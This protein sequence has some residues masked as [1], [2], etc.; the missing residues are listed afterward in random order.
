MKLDQGR[1]RVRQPDAVRVGRA[2]SR[3]CAT[4]IDR[5]R[6]EGVTRAVPAR[7]GDH[8]LRLRGRVLHGR[9]AGHRVRACSRR[10]RRRPRAWSSRSGCPSITR[11]RSTTRPRCSSTAGSSG[12]VA[13][14]FLA[15]D[16][17]H[18][19]PRWFKAWPP[20][21]VDVL[22]R[23]AERRH[24]PPLPDRRPRVRRRRRPHRLRDLRGRVGREPSRHRPRAARRRHHP[25][26]RRA[27]HFAFGKFAVRQR[28]VI[29]G[30]RAFGVA[31]LYAN[32]LG[33]EAGR[34]IY[35]GGALIASGGELLARGRRLVVPRRRAR[36][37]GRS[38]STATAASR[39]AAAATA[40]ATTPRPQVIEHA[41]R[42]ARAQARGAAAAR[43]A[44]GRI[45]ASLKEEE[46]ARAVALGLWDYL[47]KSRAQGYVVSLSGGA[48]SAAC[49]VLVATAVQLAFAELGAG[50]VR[51]RLPWCRRLVEALDR[52]GSPR[53]VVGALLTCAYQPTENSGPV[54]RA[55]GRAGRRRAVGAE[56]HVIDVERPAQGVHRE[57]SSRRSAARSTWDTDD[58]TLQN[59]Q[60]R[61]RAP[62]IWML[63]NLRGALP[64]HDVEPHRG[65]GRLRDD[66]RRHLR[67]GSRRSAASTRRSCAQW[68]RWME[69]RGPVGVEPI[70][71]LAAINAQ[72]PT[73]E[74]RPAELA[75]RPTRPTS[76][77][78]T[79]SRRSRTRRSATSTR[80]S[81]CCRSSRRAIP[82]HAPA[83]LAIWIERFFRLWC[84]NQWKRERLRA[85]LPPRRPQR[86][87]ALV[88]PVPD[89]VG[90][91]RARARRAARL[92][93]GGQRRDAMS[94]SRY[95]YARPALTVDCV[96]FGLDEHD[97]K[98]LLIQ[99]KLDAVPARAGRCPG[100]F[101]RVDETLDE[102]ARREL[103]EEAGVTDVYLE[104]LY[105]FGDARSRSARAGR[106]RRVL[107]ARQ[108]LRPPDPRRD[109]RDGRRLVR[110]RRSAASS[111]SI[112]PTIVARA[113]ERLRGKVRYAP[114]GFELLPP[115]FTLTQLQRL[116]EII[117]GTELDKR[118]FRKKILV[119]GS[120][121]RDRRG[122]AGRAPPR[123][124]P[125]PLR[126][127]QVRSPHQAGLR[128]RD[129][130]SA[131]GSDSPSRADSRVGDRQSRARAARCPRRA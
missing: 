81:R 49:A 16:G 100:G 122:R 97:L 47:R 99:R 29:E 118:N 82:Q 55:G 104:Q 13:K 65:R 44:A 71:A 109:R 73:A 83:Q 11:R 9:P 5:A 89:P 110:P 78:T 56:F 86:R 116:Y 64:D 93:R 124:A 23:T 21:E 125:L 35:D 113:H 30:S 128:V 70:A 45:G 41:V 98:V 46:F 67:A 38:T 85:E 117:L 106:H 115:R 48:D 75:R 3:T 22:E 105:T 28:F 19:E 112:T 1:R 25:A 51:Q 43:R 37:R 102:A 84:R 2:T 92:R 59:I 127:P 114:V 36:D 94:R 52:K 87:S 119:D 126:S 33:N 121:R 80:R 39:R 10:S 111:R 40:R 90:R 74:L 6:A 42:V 32:L 130:V 103:E 61:V 96:V 57:R 17:I 50:G 18:Y 120:A 68:L 108:A 12:F 58:V 7:A 4:A 131:A 60:A 76:C 20:G 26:T 79:S 27:S 101:V 15:G 123:R 54:T 72:Q 34:V 62:S 66:G 88:V 24:A 91:L 14:Q 8:R 129:V 31:Y 77:R 63:A 53:D 107:R 95:E 69:T